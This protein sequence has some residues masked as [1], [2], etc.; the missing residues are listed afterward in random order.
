VIQPPRAVCFDLD[1][2]LYPQASWLAGAWDAV[3]A[4]AAR[5]GVAEEALREALDVCAAQGSD[6]GRIIDRALARVGAEQLP[7]G[8]LVAAFR[9]YEPARLDLYPGAGQA[10]ARLA[11][12]VPLGLISDGDPTIQRA[13][14]AALGVA[15]IFGVVV[16]SDDLGRDHRKPD[17]LPFEVAVEALG[18][19]AADIVYVGDRPAKDVAG[20]VAAGLTAVRVRTGEWASDPDDPRAVQSCDTVVEAINALLTRLGRP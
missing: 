4:A 10:L 14:L 3:A 12:R 20:A 19:P 1:D 16:W 5:S 11:E 18:V 15:P 7:V 17:P 13:K 2:T 6:S 9:S 8:P